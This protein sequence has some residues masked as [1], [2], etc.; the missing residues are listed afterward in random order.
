MHKED[1]YRSTLEAGEWLFHKADAGDC[2]FLIESGMLEVCDEANGKLVAQ[3][4]PGEFI[5]EMSLLDGLPRSASVRALLPSRLRL[6]TREMLAEKLTDSDPMLRM[7]LKMVLRRFRNT[8]ADTGHDYRAEEVTDVDRVEVTRRLEMEYE[9]ELALERNELELYYQPI[10]NLQNMTTAGFESLIRWH[11]PTRGFVSPSVFIP[12]A[13]DSS[14]IVRIGRWVL[15]EACAAACRFG[16]AHRQLG[17][18]MPLPFVGVNVSG[19][20]LS[21]TRLHGDVMSAIKNAGIEAHR[22]KLEVT[23]T[24]MMEC[25][26]PA[27]EVLELCRSAGVRVAVDDFGTGYS[28]LSYLQKIPVDTLKVDQSFVKQMMKDAGSRKI[29][30]AI[31]A[32]AKGVGMDVVGEGIEQPEQASYLYAMGVA[33]GQGFLFSKAVPEAQAVQLLGHCFGDLMPTLAA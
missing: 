12:I 33:Q 21:T 11:S 29:L 26:D 9:L 22:I 7:L 10:V 32:M 28:S 16:V 1:T 31:A 17:L 4:G 6:I 23:E 24:Q 19:R 14:L 2:A 18:P 13:E 3:L 27:L 15:Q 20:Q 5:G 8:M 30:R 25:L